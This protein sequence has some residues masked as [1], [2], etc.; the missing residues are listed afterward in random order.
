MEQADTIAA[1][2][3]TTIWLPPPTDSV[4]QQGYMPTDLY[5]LNSRYGSEDELRRCVVKLQQAGLKVLADV[6]INHRCAQGQ[7]SKGIWNQFGGRMDWDARAI[8]R[9]DKKFGGRGNRS[10]GDSWPG[11]PNL[12]HSQDFVRSDLT[13]WLQWMR[14]EIGFDGWR[15]DFVR[16]YG[17]CYVQHYVQSTMPSFAVAEFWDTLDYEG[18]IPKVNQDRHRQQMIDWINDGKGTAL[19]FDFTLKG[20]LH[21]A[22][23]RNEFGRL[24][25]REGRPP[26][27]TGWWPARSSPFLCNHDC[28]STQGHWRFPR[29]GLEQ[30]Y[31]YLLTHP[32][33]PCLFWDDL[34][35]PR[36]QQSIRTLIG[37]RQRNGIHCRSEVRCWHAERSIYV[38]EIDGCML[39]KMGPAKYQPEEAHW[40]S[41]ASGHHWEIWEKVQQ[42]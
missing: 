3:V 32:G 25:D 30:G 36:L 42:H 2:G 17:G 21:A 34:M 35:E 6:V 26:G 22:F 11:A 4:S 20:I 5:N 9:D 41:V 23:E 12:D 15:F 37:V 8:V 31:A 39:M 27:L 10:S 33:T 28:D 7:D 40:R 1:A 29:H 19:C 24:R 13:E 16:G 18:S 38:A 14:N